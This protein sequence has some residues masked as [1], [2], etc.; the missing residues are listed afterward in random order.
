MSSPTTM[1]QDRRTQQAVVSEMQRFRTL[2]CGRLGPYRRAKGNVAEL[3][4]AKKARNPEP[5]GSLGYLSSNR[6]EWICR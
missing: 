2:I 3:Q 6:M 4:G 5:I 1:S